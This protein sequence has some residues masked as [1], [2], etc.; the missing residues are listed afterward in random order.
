MPGMC[1]GWERR[2]LSV[3]LAD[4]TLAIAICDVCRKRQWF[5]NG[6]PISSGEALGRALSA[7]RLASERQSIV[8]EPAR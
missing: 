4:D 2:I 6:A 7:D 5:R 8:Q 1:C 3:A